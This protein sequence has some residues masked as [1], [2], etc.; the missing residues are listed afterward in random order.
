MLPPGVEI[1]G[2]PRIEAKVLDNRNA[3]WLAGRHYEVLIVGVPVTNNRE[4]EGIDGNYYLA[5]WHTVG[6]NVVTAREELGWPALWA[7]VSEPRPHGTNAYS[8]H[9]SWLGFRFFEMELTDL[10]EPHDAD[11][12]HDVQMTYKYIPVGYSE[13]AEV[14]RLIVNDRTKYWSSA[15][16]VKGIDSTKPEAVGTVREGKGNFQFFRARWEDMPTQYNVVNALAR[17]PL[18]PYSA[19]VYDMR[20]L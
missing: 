11:P 20:F 8:A 12:V 4:G 18:E 7:D 2:E 5:E 3:F 16:A 15:A 9:A 19:Q 1:R 10:G 14:S 13:G 17:L 6:D